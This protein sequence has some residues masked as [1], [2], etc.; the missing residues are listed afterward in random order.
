MK[1]FLKI[2][3]V[4]DR[5][6]VSQATW[7]RWVKEGNAPRPRKLGANCVRWSIVDLTKWEASKGL[8]D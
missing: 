4:L 5:Y 6:G 8:V 3:E 1:P 2:S 7:Y